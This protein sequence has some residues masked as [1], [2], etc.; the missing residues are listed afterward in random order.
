MANYNETAA[1]LA[2][3]REVERRLEE[4]AEGTPEAEHLQAEA[5]RLR[6]EIRRLTSTPAPL[7]VNDALAEV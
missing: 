6:D 1:V 5:A 3:W 7:V 4:A 2:E